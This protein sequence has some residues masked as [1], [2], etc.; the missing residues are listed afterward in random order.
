MRLTVSRNQ[1]SHVWLRKL[2][3]PADSAAAGPRIRP[4]FTL[5]LLPVAT[6]YLCPLLPSPLPLSDFVYLPI[7]LALAFT[8]AIFPPCTL[9]VVK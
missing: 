2:Q 5:L 7:A 6:S 1:Q 3:Y 4:S 8:F 9:A